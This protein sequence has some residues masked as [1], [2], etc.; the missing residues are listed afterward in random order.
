VAQAGQ[1]G[2]ERMKRFSLLMLAKEVLSGNRGWLPQWREAT[3][4][5]AYDVFVI[6]GGGH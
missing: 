6:G 5:S 1:Q 4:Q 3:P 2:D